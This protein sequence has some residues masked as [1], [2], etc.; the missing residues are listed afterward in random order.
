M[1]K[2]KLIRSSLHKDV[3]STNQSLERINSI[4]NKQASS[5]STNVTTQEKNDSFHDGKLSDAG[6]STLKSLNIY[7]RENNSSIR[8]RKRSFCESENVLETNELVTIASKVSKGKTSMSK[9]LNSQVSM[10]TSFMSSQQEN[11]QL[12]RNSVSMTN[13]FL[14]SANSSVKKSIA[15]KH[16]IANSNSSEETSDNEL[17]LSYNEY[18]VKRKKQSKTTLD[19]SSKNIPQDTNI[20]CHSPRKVCHKSPIKTTTNPYVS[21]RK[22]QD[23]PKEFQFSTDSEKHKINNK[24]LKKYIIDNKEH[25]P[26]K[27][28][29]HVSSVFSNFLQKCGIVLSTDGTYSLSK[30]L[31]YYILLS[32]LQLKVE[33]NLDFAC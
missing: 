2:R 4:S 30:F 27:Q 3:Q 25:L 22:Q 1:D 29:F 9:Q 11:I 5:C 26:E 23:K 33:E 12:S 18:N 20:S 21:Q 10:N 24:E 14:N 6:S 28:N 7:S 15:Q 8:N 19:R 32:V 16:K 13:K 31:Y 17:D